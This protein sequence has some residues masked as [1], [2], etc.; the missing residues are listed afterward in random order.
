MI[1]EGDWLRIKPEWQDQGDHKYHWIACSDEHDGRL[2]I[3]PMGTNLRFPPRQVVRTEMVEARG[4]RLCVAD[5]PLGWVFAEY[6]P[7]Q[8]VTHDMV[9]F[10]CDRQDV[11]VNAHR[12]VL[13]HDTHLAME[14]LRD[15]Q[16]PQATAVPARSKGV[17]L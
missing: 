6:A 7:G 10:D 14:L 12:V 2:E 11:Q 3:M 4:L 5:N 15:F 16:P 1:K 9:Q 17:S 13:F 8:R